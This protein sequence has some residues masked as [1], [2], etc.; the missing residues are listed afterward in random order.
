MLRV[1]YPAVADSTG[2]PYALALG[3]GQRDH[4]NDEFVFAL[5]CEL[6]RL[7]LHQ[8]AVE[9]QLPY[10]AVADPGIDRQTAGFIPNDG[11]GEPLL[12]VV[13]PCQ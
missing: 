7:F 4:K 12:T 2:P 9:A 1:G 6:V 10:P 3:A 5:N 13:V 8:P 11:E